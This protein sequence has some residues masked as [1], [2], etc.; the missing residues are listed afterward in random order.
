MI[1]IGFE[2]FSRHLSCNQRFS[3]GGECSSWRQL[4]SSGG[5][6][7]S[8]YPRTHLIE[9]DLHIYLHSWPEH[10]LSVY[11]KESDLW[12][13]VVRFW[14]CSFRCW[15]LS[16][17]GWSF[18]DLKIRYSP[19][20]SR[21][22]DLVSSTTIAYSYQSCSQLVLLGKE[23]FSASGTSRHLLS[24]RQTYYLVHHGWH[25]LLAFSHGCIGLAGGA[26]DWTPM[27]HS[28]YL[29]SFDGF[30]LRYYYLLS[31]GLSTV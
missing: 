29:A 18:I 15:N 6:E 11:S 20:Y 9:R 13:Q 22:L 4:S 8:F 24:R 3:Y 7:A 1:P 28:R 10:S 21:T 25:L 14:F 2:E 16:G 30:P 17:F 31:Y 26:S 27:D 23:G 12:F 19:S 5:V